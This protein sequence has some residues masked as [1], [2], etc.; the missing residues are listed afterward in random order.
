[1]TIQTMEA[2]KGDDAKAVSL[3]VERLVDLLRTQVEQEATSI[4]KREDVSL[5]PNTNV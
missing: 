2:E 5:N 1:M 3:F 4:H